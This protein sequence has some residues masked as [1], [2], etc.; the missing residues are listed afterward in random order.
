MPN[1]AETVLYFPF[2]ASSAS[3]GLVDRGG[4][5]TLIWSPP[6]SFAG[7]GYTLYGALDNVAASLAQPV[8]DKNG[9]AVFITCGSGALCCIDGATTFAWPTYL[10]LVAP[11]AASLAAA[12]SLT[13]IVRPV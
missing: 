8:K 2:A 9:T 7:S 3:S 12:A 4:W 6:S 10:M 11:A 13:A 1:T 5:H